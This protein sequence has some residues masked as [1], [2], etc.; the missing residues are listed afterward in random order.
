MIWS[1]SI[2]K[3]FIAQM[4]PLQLAFLHPIKALLYKDTCC[5]LGRLDPVSFPF[6]YVFWRGGLGSGKE[7]RLLKRRTEKLFLMQGQ[8]FCLCSSPTYHLQ[9]TMCKG[10][11]PGCRSP[12]RLCDAS[13]THG[14]PTATFQ[15]GK[16]LKT[17]L[18]KSLHPRVIPSGHFF[19]CSA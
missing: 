8:D 3:Y 1:Q 6:M 15:S 12:S 19:F 16:C 18:L 2:F 5:P 7:N 4:E 11:L 17:D 14:K 10:C 13:C 9:G